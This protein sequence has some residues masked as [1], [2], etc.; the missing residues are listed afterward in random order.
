M[1]K[2]IKIGWVESH[3]ILGLIVFAGIPFIAVQILKLII[4]TSFREAVTGAIKAISL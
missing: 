2:G 1:D 4:D 3:K